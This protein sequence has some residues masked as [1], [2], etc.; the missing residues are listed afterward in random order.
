MNTGLPATSA[1]VPLTA[2]PTAVIVSASPSG[3]VS[4][5]SSVAAGMVRGVSSVAASVSA[6]ASGASFTAPTVI[7]AV[8]V[9]VSMP[10]VPVLP[11]S[12]VVIVRVTDPLVF[13]GGMKLGRDTPDRKAFT[14]AAVPSSVMVPVLLP[15]TVTPPPEAAVKMPDVTDSVTRIAPVAASTSAIWR[16]ESPRARSSFVEKDG[17]SVL[18]G[19]SLTG[20]TVI[21]TVSWSVTPAR[22][23]PTVR[24]SGP[25]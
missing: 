22:T 15:P 25:L 20:V 12:V 21:A 13:A 8:S 18:R 14:A 1:T 4:L 6:V 9:S 5:A 24:V 10:P 2:P 16:P 17:G 3:S 23:V 19:A 11:L 7:V